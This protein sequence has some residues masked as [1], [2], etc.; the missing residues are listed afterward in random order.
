MMYGKQVKFAGVK[1]YAFNLM[2]VLQPNLQAKITL[3]YFPEI[4][5]YASDI[6]CS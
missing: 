1:S 4:G 2:A 6:D 5:S 3:I